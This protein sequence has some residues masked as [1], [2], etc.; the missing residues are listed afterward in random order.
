MLI[1]Y[2]KEI[3]MHQFYIKKPDL[4]TKILNQVQDEIHTLLFWTYCRIYYLSF[5]INFRISLVF[6]MNLY[7][8]SQSAYNFEVKAETLKR[9]RPPLAGGPSSPHNDT[10][11][12]KIT[13]KCCYIATI[14]PHL[15]GEGGDEVF[16]KLP[17]AVTVQTNWTIPNNSTQQN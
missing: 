8:Y 3:L 4:K 9:G 15:W 7:V 14:T 1:G 11:T 2:L 6:I 5:W 10:R 16:D 13:K 12:Y 17:T